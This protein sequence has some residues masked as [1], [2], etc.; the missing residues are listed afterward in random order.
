MNHVHLFDSS[1]NWIAFR[2]DS[3]VYNTRG[4]WIGWLAWGDDEVVTPDGRYLGHIFPNNRLY[5][6]VSGGFR[7]YP[8]DPGYPGYGGNPARP[9]IVGYSPLPSGAHDL[10]PQELAA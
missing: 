7:K 8:G 1:G 2:V 5:R 3:Y 9:E 10:D 4:E 6:Q